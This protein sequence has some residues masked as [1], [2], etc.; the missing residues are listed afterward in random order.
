MILL[1]LTYNLPC[2]ILVPDKLSLKRLVFFISPLELIPERLSERL[3]ISLDFSEAVLHPYLK[4][5]QPLLNILKLDLLDIVMILMIL[6]F[7][8]LF[9]DLLLDMLL[10]EVNL[11]LD[12]IGFHH[13]CGLLA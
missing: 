2:V 11:L 10:K 3:V 6:L 8:L 5:S 7:F 12:H 1:E 9:R 13:C 4:V